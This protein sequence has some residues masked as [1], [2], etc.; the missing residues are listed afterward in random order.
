MCKY[1]GLPFKLSLEATPYQLSWP[2]KIYKAVRGYQ[3]TKGFN[4]KTTD[5]AQSLWYPIVDVVPA[6]NS[7]ED[8]IEEQHEMELVESG[9]PPLPTVHN[10]L[11]S[12]LDPNGYDWDQVTAD[13]LHSRSRNGRRDGMNLKLPK[14]SLRKLGH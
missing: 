3:I 10:D 11:G 1:L 4:P 12:V 13:M 2:T 7:F 8:I 6:E 5:F 14:S 9:N